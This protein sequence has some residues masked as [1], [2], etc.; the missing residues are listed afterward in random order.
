LYKVMDLQ[1]YSECATT[2][3]YVEKSH[4]PFREVLFLIRFPT[5]ASKGFFSSPPHP[6]RLWG[7]PCLMF[8]GNRVLLLLIK[9]AGRE[10]DHS[11]TSDGEVGNAW[12]YTSIHAYVFMV[13]GL[14][15][16]RNNFT[17]TLSINRRQRCEFLSCSYP[18]RR[19]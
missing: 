7:P 15:K 13:W 3:Y 18:T 12:S 19:K 16:D 14:V 10:T 1:H 9:G 5:A 8:S 17:L 4:G 11:P 6:D 2:Y